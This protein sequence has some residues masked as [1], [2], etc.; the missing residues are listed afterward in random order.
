MVTACL[1]LGTLE[2]AASVDRMRKTKSNT[3]QGE[4]DQCHDH[5]LTEEREG[6]EQDL[7]VSRPSAI[8]RP[9]RTKERRTQSPELRSG[10]RQRTC[11]PPRKAQRQR[12]SGIV[13]RI[14]KK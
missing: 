6:Y 7:V 4:T 5:I 9:T 11:R 14:S 10:A 1:S 8:G 2:S 13:R 3:E 12:G